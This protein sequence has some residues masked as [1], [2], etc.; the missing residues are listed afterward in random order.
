MH[1]G[2]FVRRNV[3]L[4]RYDERNTRPQCP[5][6]NLYGGGRLHVFADKLMEE[7]GD[8]EFKKLL[9]ESRD[10]NRSGVSEKFLEDIIEKYAEKLKE[11]DH[12]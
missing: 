10:T 11:L 6:C 12:E 8:K 9:K 5:G 2:H 4:L 1:N 7:L 3:S